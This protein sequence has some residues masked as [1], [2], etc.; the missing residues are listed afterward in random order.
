M[1]IQTKLLAAALDHLRPVVAHKQNLLPIL[2]CVRMS[3]AN[4]SLTIEATDQDQY[5]CETMA[6]DEPFD[7]VC[8]DF[9][10]FSMALAGESVEITQEGRNLFVKSYLG[11][12]KLATLD[13]IEFPEQLKP[14]KLTKQGI[15]CRD[16]AT[17]ISGVEWAAPVNCDRPILQSVHVLSSAKL[18]QVQATNGRNLACIQQAGIAATFEVLLHPALCK[19]L[20]AAMEREGSVLSTGENGVRVDYEGGFYVCKQLEGKYPNTAAIVSGK[21]I[22]LGTA[23]NAAL[24]DAFTKLNF[25]TD[26]QKT[27]AANVDFS[28]TGISLT[29]P[30]RNSMSDFNIEGRFDPY[31]CRLNV[32]SFLDAMQHIKGEQVKISRNEQ[33]N[34]II[35]QSGDVSIH[36]TEVREEKKKA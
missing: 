1:K 4:G 13:A 36:M 6:H 5:Q 8:V 2:S 29:M 15:E 20:C 30:G 7:A 11:P 22:L 16:L 19:N 14:G 3:S 23:S 17:A 31:K 10:M 18:I 35:L 34:T 32:A 27:N 33:V 24:L 9:K 21:T 26:P 12:V 25:Y 28:M